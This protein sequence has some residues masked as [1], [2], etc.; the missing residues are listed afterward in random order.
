[1]RL[2]L[3]RRLASSMSRP[4]TFSSIQVRVP[5]AIIQESEIGVNALA[6]S[7][8]EILT[9][10]VPA[11]FRVMSSTMMIENHVGECAVYGEDTTRYREVKNNNK[12][13]VMKNNM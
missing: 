2:W 11:S 7:I 5:N 8:A 10:P 12:N 9:S 13:N 3:G 1:M 4:P 6:K